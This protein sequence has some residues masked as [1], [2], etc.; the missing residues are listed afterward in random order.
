[1]YREMYRESARC[2]MKTY[3]ARFTT[4]HAVVVG[5]DLAHALELLRAAGVTGEVELTL[6]HTRTEGVQ[7]IE[8]VRRHTAPTSVTL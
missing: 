2:K 1:M 3:H 5:R 4:G 8:Q 6:L 7:V